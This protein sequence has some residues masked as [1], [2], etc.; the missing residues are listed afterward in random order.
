MLHS[1]F[2]E[3]SG[4][5]LENDVSELRVVRGGRS[6][7]NSLQPDCKSTGVAALQVP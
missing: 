2:F 5:G 3:T 4:P 1:I 6:D 7:T